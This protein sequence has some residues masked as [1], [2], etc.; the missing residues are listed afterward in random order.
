M[1]GVGLRALEGPE[2]VLG[3]YSGTAAPGLSQIRAAQ[4]CNRA[5]G[6][7]QG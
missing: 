7:R 3:M 4:S 2:D 5:A 6:T 1:N